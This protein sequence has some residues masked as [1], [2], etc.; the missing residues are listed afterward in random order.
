MKICH[1]CDSKEHKKIVMQ[2]NWDAWDVFMT[3]RDFNQFKNL[4]PKKVLEREDGEVFIRIAEQDGTEATY[5]TK[6]CRAGAEMRE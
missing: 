2:H 1:I 3:I 4:H 5:I 6:R